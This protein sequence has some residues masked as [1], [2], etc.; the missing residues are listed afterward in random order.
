MSFKEPEIKKLYYSITEVA[1]MFDVNASLIRFWER[2]F[3]VLKPKKSTSGTR[4]Y[5]AN[6]IEQLK[7]VY[8]LVKVQ[9]LTLDGAKK[10]LKENKKQI[11]IE[12][13]TNKD[14]L[15]EVE[16]KLMLIRKKLID[17]SDTL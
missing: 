11:K 17:L 1:E 10:F 2:E 3:D 14:S 12:L 4:L 7:V 16:N 8:D 15:N 9:C 13:K 5:T 6:D